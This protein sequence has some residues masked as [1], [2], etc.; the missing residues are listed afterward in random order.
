LK[1][2][3]GNKEATAETVMPMLGK[4]KQRRVSGYFRK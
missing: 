3:F 2:V 1:T 4:D